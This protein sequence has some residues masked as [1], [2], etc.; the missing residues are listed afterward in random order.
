MHRAARKLCENRCAMQLLFNSHPFLL[1][2]LPSMLLGWWAGSWPADG[3]GRFGWIVRRLGFTT[4]IAALFAFVASAAGHQQAYVLL[5]LL[6]PAVLLGWWVAI[7]RPQ[8]RLGYLAF[9]SWTFYVLSYPDSPFFGGH[10]HSGAFVGLALLPL[11]LLSTTVDYWAGKLI[12]RELD[13]GHEKTGR[14][15]R[16]L[17][18]ALIFNLGLLGVFK[19]LGFFASTFNE[20][21]GLFISGGD[22][23]SVPTVVLP[24]GISFY[25]FN[26]MSYTIDIYREK[27]KPARGM[28][29]YAA[30]VAL[31]PHLIAGPI[32]RYSDID[33]QL[34]K[35]HHKLTGE[36][37]ALGLWFL[38][39]GLFKKVV[40]ANAL[41]GHVDRLY[42]Q[43]EHLAVV[44]GW[45]AALGYSLQLYFDFSAYSD[46]A[47]G[48]ALLMGLRFPQNF[49]S[50]YKARNP[51]DFWRRWHMSL[52]RWL[53][54]YLYITMGG[55]RGGKLKTLRNL[56]LTMF[57]GGLWHGAAWVFVL[58]GLL[59]GLGLV[60][61]RVASDAGIVPPWKWLSRA[62]CFIFVVIL[63]VPF[64]SGNVDLVKHGRSTEVMGNVLGAM[65]GQNGLGLGHL[66][67][68]DA[69]G[70][71]VPLTFVGLLVTL[72]VFV[73][74]APNTWEFRFRPT[75]RL[76][77]ATAVLATWS[78]LLLSAPSPFLY[79]QF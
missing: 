63:W 65:F 28:L 38:V 67:H 76:A 40:I 17:I 49:N 64:R 47:V 48:L 42:G 46:M 74:V 75:R 54:D 8:Y 16:I 71:Q 44:S 30:F 19:Y 25:T 41:A 10:V 18:A 32:V 36:M 52:S 60:V 66:S 26:S 13:A 3:W 5:P 70:F 14:A 62:M 50:P 15:K 2:F 22:A 27:V 29:E 33:E 12:Q 73:N 6:V 61:H 68:G 4:G 39:I 45:A 57:I 35:L 58:W 55:N 34:R 24:I 56:F 7:D 43:S 53:T 31:F 1:L 78:V 11:M 59:H 77:L 51:S 20:V 79:F 23:V 21:A 72:L 37:A 9:M 69:T